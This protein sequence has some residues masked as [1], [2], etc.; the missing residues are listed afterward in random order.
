M[1]NVHNTRSDFVFKVILVG[2]SG[3]GKSALITRFAD[4]TFNASFL[5]TIGIDFKIRHLRVDN[6]VV[7]LNVWDTAGQDRFRYALPDSFILFYVLINHYYLLF[8]SI[9]ASYYR[10]ADVVLIAYDTTNERSFRNVKYWLDEVN[11]H[12]RGWDTKAPPVMKVLVGTKKDLTQKDEKTYETSLKIRKEAEKFAKDNN[13]LFWETSSKTS[14]NVDQLFYQ[15]AYDMKNI[16][17]ARPKIGRTGLKKKKILL[18][19]S[20][21]EDNNN[22]RGCLC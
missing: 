19:T 4:D 8:R 3:V 18:N 2:D 15:I 22:N 14:A 17:G 11:N 5:S 16:K 13:M 7:K 6:A 10:C 20:G 9:I 21:L 1:A 12:L